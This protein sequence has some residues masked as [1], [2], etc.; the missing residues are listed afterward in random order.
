MTEAAA[1]DV[2][3]PVG[4]PAIV[5]VHGTRLSR[6]MWRPQMEDLRDRYR[7]IAVDLPGHAAIVRQPANQLSPD[8]DLGPRPVT[9]AVG[10][11]TPAEARDAL[12]FALQFSGQAG[13]L[14]SDPGDARAERAEGI[15]V[16]QR[17]LALAADQVG[18]RLA[19]LARTARALHHAA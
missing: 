13:Q 8:S 1:Y 10:P 5:F 15:G 3:G 16:A 17:Q 12:A 4:A 19:D 18:H 6:T 9:T 11:L 2:D 7:V 14:G